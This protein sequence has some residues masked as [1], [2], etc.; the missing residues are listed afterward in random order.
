MLFGENGEFP[1]RHASA[2]T[3][4][5]D[6][7]LNHFFSIFSLKVVDLGEEGGGG[8]EEEI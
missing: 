8:E 1:S 2:R 4:E 6:F 5:I 3:G 7:P